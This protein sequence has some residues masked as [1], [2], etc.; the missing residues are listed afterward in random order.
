MKMKI[1]LD[2]FY[3]ELT[4][5]YLQDRK[6]EVQELKQEV[7]QANFTFLKEKF[8]KIA[9]SGGG[10]GLK[11]ISSLASQIENLSDSQNIEDIKKIFSEYETLLSNIEI[12]F[13]D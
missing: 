4:P 10:Y 3:K 12:E 5:D 2:S 8:H 6:A 9:G 11:E 13:E 7:E 1:K